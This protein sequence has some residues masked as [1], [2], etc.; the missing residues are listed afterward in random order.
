MLLPDQPD[1]HS[2]EDWALLRVLLRLEHHVHV[3][4]S[5]K[6]REAVSTQRETIPRGW[7]EV[8][9]VLDVGSCCV[10]DHKCYQRGGRRSILSAGATDSA[11]QLLLVPYAVDHNVYCLGKRSAL[12]KLAGETIGGPRPLFAQAG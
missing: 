7:K 9:V 10:W 3:Y 5:A 8:A 6:T 12:G 11:E 4:Q 2:V 1:A